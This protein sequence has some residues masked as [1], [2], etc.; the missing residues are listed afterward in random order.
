MKKRLTALVCIA[1]LTC[2][3]VSL[4]VGASGSPIDAFT[5]VSA[6]AEGDMITSTTWNFYTAW[7]LEDPVGSW[8]IDD[9]T[10]ARYNQNQSGMYLDNNNAV[11][12]LEFKDSDLEGVEAIGQIVFTDL[13]TV[14]G[15][16]FGMTEVS[17]SDFER[18][19]LVYSNDFET[20]QEAPF[21]VTY[22]NAA[23]TISGAGGQQYSVDLFWHLNLET[24]VLAKYWALNTS[25]SAAW[26][27]TGHKPEFGIYMDWKHYYGVKAAAADDVQTS[28]EAATT[29][30]VT[31]EMQETETV[32]TDTVSTDITSTDVPTTDAVGTDAVTTDVDGTENVITDTVTNIPE[33]NNA[34]GGAPSTS[35]FA[36]G[37]IAATAVV[38]ACAVFFAKKRKF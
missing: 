35:D 29:D 17:P 19:T 26:D 37:S 2:S 25:E 14:S 1:L 8:H 18:L 23:E 24:P 9:F 28:T 38:A 15:D 3:L 31:T 36:V 12:I 4:G 34:A 11:T 22:H 7:G 10:E 30:A 5:E 21:T 33:T 27:A 20:W 6:P 16:G 32:I 13:Y